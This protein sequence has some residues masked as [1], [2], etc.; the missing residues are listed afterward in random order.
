[1]QRIVTC[2]ILLAL[3]APVCTAGEI[4]F[5]EDFALA[6]DRTVP[7]K[8]LIPGTEDYY[9]YNCLHY[10][11]SG[12]LEE[13][14]RMLELWIKRYN[15]TARVR[16]IENRQALLRYSTDPKSSL[17]FIRRR[18]GLTFNHQREVL[19]RKTKL[20]TRLAPS[21]IPRQ[22]L[23]ARALRRHSHTLQGF[24]ERALDWVIAM[25]LSR[26][27][28]RH[29]LHRMKRPDYP[30]LPARVV[31]DLNYEHSRGF[32]S[33]GIHKL[34]LLDQLKECLKLK[35]DLLNQTNFVNVYLTKLWPDA[36]VDWRHDAE[37]RQAYLDRLWAFVSRLQ[38]A[39]NSLKAHVLYHRLAHD[40]ALGIY[41]KNRFMTYLKLPRNVSYINRD[42]IKRYEHR[43]YHAN[44]NANFDGQT[45]L[46]RIGNDEPLVRSYLM[47]YFVTEDSYKAY[48]P[49]IN[50]IYLKRCFAETK[51]VNGLGDMEQWYSMLP[52]EMY[53]ALKD[54]IDLDFAYTNKVVFG[55]GDQVGLDLHVK[56]VKSL[57][58]KVF[59]IN[60]LNYYRANAKEINTGIDLDGLVAN[61]EK[62]YAYAEPALRRVKR[63]FEFPKL[64][65]RGV[66]VIEFIGNGKSSRALVRK[67]T[68]R[69]LARTSTAGHV[70]TILDEANKKLQ[71]ASLWLAGH[72]YSAEEDGTITVPF[73]NKPVRQPIVLIHGGFASLD[74]F[75]HESE[76]YR[77]SAGI[78]VDREALLKRK[79]ASVVI[80]P[81]L[82]LNGSPVTLSVLEDITLVI[83]SVDR[84]K[85]STTKEIGD[86]KL[87]EDRETVYEFQV[88]GNLATISFTLKAKVQNLSQAKKIDLQASQA[89]TLN[90][91]DRTE[92]IEDLHLA[93]FDGSYVV[94][95]L[96][97]TGEI[98]ADRPVHFVL[99]HRDFRDP[100]NV[101]LQTDKAGRIVLGPLKEIDW[102][103]A[104]GPQSTQH[105]WPLLGD[106]HNYPGSVHGI[107]GDT[108]L[109]PFMIDVESPQ[110]A[111]L[112]FLEKRGATFV[113][114]RFNALS[115]KNGLLRIQ[116]IPAGDYDLLLKD[117]GRR[118]NVRITKGRKSDSY[119]LSKTRHLQVR[120]AQPLQIA[121]VNADKD[122]VKIRLENG[123]K[124]ARVHV[125]ATR[126]VPEYEVYGNLHSVYF[127][128]PYVIGVRPP[129]TLYVV[130]R[131][132]GDEY[133]YILER[134]HATKFPGNM[135]TRPSLLL[136][137]WAIR[138][139]ETTHDEAR[140]GDKFAA[141][142]G[143]GRGGRR[144]SQRLG[145][146][147][148][149]KGKGYGFANL[150]FL[151]QS[152]AVL[153]N[154]KPD[155]D[156]LVTIKRDVLGAH[157]H[158]HVVAIDPQNTAYRRISLPEIEMD[159]N[160][161]RLASGLDPDE[162]FT[163][164]KQITVVGKN[165]P[166]VLDDITTSSF[167]TYDSLDKVHNLFATLSS[168]STLVE[169]G[170]ILGW[171][172]LKPEE[173]REKYTKYACHEL[174]Y[175][176]YEKDPEFSTRSSSRTSQTREIRRSSTTGCSAMICESI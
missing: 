130:G 85:V 35:G 2:V 84:E 131:N 143:R 145:A 173:K 90:G 34:M 117:T 70:F 76:Q 157:Q 127:P 42:Y 12:R 136:N 43:R 91:I 115:I 68:L 93:C 5:I 57:I 171:P 72:Q 78:Y 69:F 137:P 13:V 23:T 121:S 152:T 92:K 108:I 79:K 60:A 4:G 140:L 99:K 51:I 101:S 96:G 58:V 120:N 50:D 8:Q 22:T 144:R 163:E 7:L 94:D 109:L 147:I 77:L 97:K 175:F 66:Y 133:R 25:N 86:F 156:G 6:K 17:E 116:D 40:R 106:R 159:F 154:L 112:S 38:P 103:N 105:R 153:T 160:D 64:N 107:A 169:F 80:R 89:F 118:I 61:E 55:V 16:E 158:I 167:E 162:H 126:Y 129:E 37:A 150:D 15:R 10:Q 18:L 75:Q 164:Q 124:F 67:G 52:P 134:K 3:A 65:R 166:F 82:T 19:G 122:T 172:E 45:Q 11:N 165:A 62:T 28:Q 36:D 44:L 47:H 39:H 161:L 170:F 110:R 139:T 95:V 83:T 9:Y 149:G 148:V 53:K 56:N 128:E 87:Y 14:D 102:V 132:I 123:S 24:E 59:E 135:L 31:D 29:L 73:S 1:M 46:P 33:H 88:P 119:V 30:N 48:E 21:L 174:N 63:H 27:R 113:N 151:S 32:G 100:V 49:Y 125:F 41:D 146:G 26:A 141:R 168:N 71:D 138:K 111:E 20:P 98:K 74:H 176:L 114:D 155:K 81:S 104:T 142:E 54:R